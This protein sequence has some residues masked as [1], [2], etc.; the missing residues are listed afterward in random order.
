LPAADAQDDPSM[1][2]RLIYVT[3][4]KLVSWMVLRTPIR[5]PPKKSRSWSC[6]TNSPCSNE[7]RHGHE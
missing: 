5:H 7:T 6:A 3:V 1:A 2:L 4:S